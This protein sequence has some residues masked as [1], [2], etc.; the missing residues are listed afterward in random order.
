MDDA[1]GRAGLLAAVV[2][3]TLV[4]HDPIVA[5]LG[6]AELSLASG[7]LVLAGTAAFALA[8]VRDAKSADSTGGSNA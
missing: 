4:L 6:E 7:L 5:V 3:N 1:L 2:G 8:W